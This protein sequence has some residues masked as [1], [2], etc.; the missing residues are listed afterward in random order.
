M[1]EFRQPKGPVHAVGKAMELVG[2]LLRARRPMTLAELSE[3]AGYPKSTTHA[4]LATLQAYQM[5]RQEP[6]GK[7][8]LGIGLYE[9]GCAVAA[10]WD[11]R[12][13]AAPYLER[14]AQQTGTAAYLF[15]RSE[16]HAL[17]VD[18]CVFGAGDG[19]LV[20]AEPGSRLPLHATA[21]GKLLL[22]SAS[23]AELRRYCRASGLPP[24]TRHTITAEQELRAEL[25][26]IRARGYAAEDGEY[27]VGLRG[28][29]APVREAN[30]TV[31]WAL[32]VM[33]LFPRPGTE[34]FR[35]IAAETVAA[36]AALSAAL[37]CDHGL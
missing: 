7:Y 14:L 33:G 24:S 8:C 2:L 32:S 29:A 16:D 3:R 9:C 22:A 6:D 27:R 23:E 20:S 26:Q 10:A 30:G 18:R 12:Q 31:S 11:V 35:A 21:P 5:I 19:L 37:G 15:L 36:A 17:C 25:E 13:T 1:A 34:E 4:L 28:A